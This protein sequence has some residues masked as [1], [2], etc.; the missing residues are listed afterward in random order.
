MN[1]SIAADNG[2]SISIAEVCLANSDTWDKVWRECDY[3]TY[4]QSREWAEIW[5]N[6]TQGKILPKPKLVTF[7]DG[8]TALIP[9][10]SQKLYWGLVS[11]HMSSVEGG[12][13]GWISTDPLQL[14]HAVLL[15]DYLTVRNRINIVWRLNPYDDLVFKAQ[16]PITWDDETHAINLEKDFKSIYTNQS[17]AV[18]KAR[19]AEKSG[20]V[21]SIEDSLEGWREYYE[22]YQETI[23]RWGD[24][25]ISVYAWSLFQEIFQR[26]SP[27]I[28]LWVARYQGKIVSGALCFYAKKHSVYWHGSSLEDYFQFRPVNLLMYEIMKDA[29]SKEYTW[30]DFNP[31][32]GL[33]GVAA[34]KESLGASPLSSPIV[35]VQTPMKKFIQKVEYRLTKH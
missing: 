28:K 33:K 7:S 25:T 19:K 35:L 3:A 30:F 14:E 15:V 34:F 31:S 10:S 16:P 1:T 6:H 29:H 18:R 22:V 23:K 4:F 26:K 21:V 11:D 9:L 5:S 17:S 20:V 32:A 24:N 13:G 12:F 27:H 2:A 8:K